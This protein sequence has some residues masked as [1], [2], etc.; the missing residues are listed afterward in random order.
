[1]KTTGRALA[2]L[3]LIYTLVFSSTVVFGAVTI[4]NGIEGDGRWE[5]VV[6]VAGDSTGGFLDPMGP[7]GLTRVVYW[8][9]TLLEIDD[10]PPIALYQSNITTPPTLKPGTNEVES[11]G[12]FDG[13]NGTVTWKAVSSIETHIYTL[14]LTFTSQNP[15]GLIR[16]INYLDGDSSDYNNDLLVVLNGSEPADIRL[17]TVGK[18]VNHGV[19][20]AT[21]FSSTL[22]A[23]FYGW[24][25]DE[26]PELIDDIINVSISSSEIFSPTG[27][28]D[29]ESL[30]PTS[31]AG[32]PG[33]VVYGPND[34]TT[35]MAFDLDPTATSATVTFV[36]GASPDGDSPFSDNPAER[37][38][39]AKAGADQ[40]AVVNSLVTLDGSGSSDPDNDIVSYSWV[41]TGGP[42]VELSNAGEALS[43]FTPVQATPEG[44]LLTFTLT[45][46]DS[47]GLT[48]T[49]TTTVRVFPSV[50]ETNMPD[51]IYKDEGTPLPTISAYIQTYTVGSILVILTPDLQ[52]WYVFIEDNWENGLSNTPDMGKEGHGLTM[53]FAQGGKILTE[54]SYAGGGSDSW[55]LTRT[56]A[57]LEDAPPVD[58]IYKQEK[59]MNLYL[60]TYSAGSTLFIF[61]PNLVDWIVFLDDNYSDG[62]AVSGDLGD[63]GKSLVMT[64][65]G[66]G[67]YLSTIT[68][69]LG[70]NLTF[71]VDL[72]F[73]APGVA[74]EQ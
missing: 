74:A 25:A 23:F 36:L 70:T 19:A 58:G 60:Q 15:L 12:S 47:Q 44:V 3:L 21:E 17:L 33:K 30:P 50:I 66:T 65:N 39:T 16:V 11:A 64:P 51:G 22:N 10:D 20:H 9:F 34:V 14:T 31:A 53:S 43:T 7:T 32:Y 62:L 27:R 68:D 73:E 4:D 61:T 69:A 26:K 46:T 52:H 49:D 63:L 40:T 71:Q 42:T 24:A 29:T 6:D 1:M 72:D 59:G 38:P 48:D 55:T 57:A 41:Q 67:S 18:N 8:F 37:G 28:V 35:A 13:A 5:V 54:L 45:V 56:F 2:S